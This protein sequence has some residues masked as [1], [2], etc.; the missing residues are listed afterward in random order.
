MTRRSI[1]LWTLTLTTLAAA[2]C[3]G[4][5]SSGDAGAER[6]KLQRIKIGFLMDTTHERWIRDRDLFTERAQFLGA[7]VVTEAGE[8]DKDRQ[9]QLADKLLAEDIKVL[10]LVPND[11]TAAAAIVEKAKAKNV[12]VISYDRLVRNA[13]VDLYVTFDNVKVGEMQAEYLLNRAPTGNYLLIGGAESDDNAHQIREGQMKVLKPAIDSGKIKIVGQGWAANWRAGEAER[14]TDAAL[15]KTN[16]NL[17]AIVASNDVTAGG[18]IKALER[19]NLAGKVLVS[20]QDAELDARPPRRAGHAG[21]DGLQAARGAGA[22]GREQ[23]GAPR[24]RRRRRRGGDDGEQREEGCAGAAARSDSRRQEQHGRIAHQRRVPHQ[25]ADLRQDGHA[26]DA[27]DDVERCAD[28]ARYASMRRM[29]RCAYGDARHLER[30]ARGI[31]DPRCGTSTRKSPLFRRDF[32]N[33]FVNH[34]GSV[35]CTC[36]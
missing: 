19:A 27:L 16:N 9:A 35:P 15:K 32:A 7:T 22:H 26:V 8:G 20:G 29:R 23:R 3:G 31:R 2:A 33:S 11:A 24:E 6:Q 25:R 17:A 4:S 12:P 21:D 14:M 10:V 5:S 13:D 30:P 36:M 1:L 18:A 34:A 28:I